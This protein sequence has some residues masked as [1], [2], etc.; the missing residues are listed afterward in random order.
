MANTTVSSTLS[1]AILADGATISGTWTDTYNSSGTLIGVSGVDVTVKG[2]NG[3]TTTFTSATVDVGSAGTAGLNY[4]IHLSGTS[5]SSEFSSLYL[6]W[7]TSSET[8]TSLAT[9]TIHYGHNGAEYTSVVDTVNRKS[10]IYGLK[11][12]SGGTIVDHITC[13]TAGT[14][15]L[16]PAGEVPVEALKAGDLVLTADGRSLP[17]RWLGRSTIVAHFADALRAAPILIKAGALGEQLPTQDL[18]VSPAHALFLDGRLVEAGALVNGTSIVREAM[19][20]RFT[21]YHV[22]LA[23]HELL[24]SNGVASESFVDNVDRL[25]FDNWAEHEALED[26]APIAEMELPRVKAARQLPQGLR[27]RLAERAGLFAPVF[28]AA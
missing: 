10:T 9:G 24:V 1:N 23:S 26:T 13:F 8:P 12:T 21:Y 19:T 7:S 20:E 18:R 2:T 25:N 15:I 3:A 6:D 27:A 22:E 28:E 4:E 17:V 11:S 5:G 16:T 14:K